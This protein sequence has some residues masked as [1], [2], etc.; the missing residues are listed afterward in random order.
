MIFILLY[1]P[2]GL[3]ISMMWAFLYV[4]AN[5]KE[6]CEVSFPSIFQKNADV[7]EFVEI[8]GSKK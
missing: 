2:C 4:K 3:K 7:S 8:Q 1:L 5:S 6:I